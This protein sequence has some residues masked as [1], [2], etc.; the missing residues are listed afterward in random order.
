ME[1]W[2]SLFQLAV[3]YYLSRIVHVPALSSSDGTPVDYFDFVVIGLA[4]YG[5]LTTGLYVFSSSLR[6]DQT[7]GTLEVLLS[8]PMPPSLTI[9]GTGTYGFGWSFVSSA[10]IIVVA[11]AAFGLR[12][13]LEPIALLAGL[14]TLMASMVLFASLGIAIGAFTLVFK[15]A[16]SLMSL[17]LEGLGLLSGVYFPIAL[18]PRPLQFLSEAIPLTWA[19]DVLRHALIAGEVETQRMLILIAS[20]IVSMP[21]ALWLFEKAATRARR[22]GSLGQY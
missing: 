18:L 12:P 19:L 9:L 14:I 8:M 15:R 3:F 17:L 1:V 16:N 20:S 5:L 4:L 6:N 10:V 21:A 22:A 11:I 7:I 13:V 2:G